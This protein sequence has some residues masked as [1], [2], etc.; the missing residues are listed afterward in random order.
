[1]GKLVKLLRM[2]IGDKY[3][4]DYSDI[5]IL[6]LKT[7]SESIM[8]NIVKISEFRLQGEEQFFNSIYNC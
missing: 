2:L 6:T 1:M 8:N 7:E 4:Y 5:V 3:G